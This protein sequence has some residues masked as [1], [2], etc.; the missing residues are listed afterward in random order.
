MRSD[1][2]TQRWGPNTYAQIQQVLKVGGG[3]PTHGPV[4]GIHWH[5]SIAD[6]VEY[7][8]TDEARQKIPWVRLTDSQGVVTIFREKTCYRSQGEWYY[9]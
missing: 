4:G 9:V 1:Q 3:D 7:I 8:A 6:R 5:M 2:G